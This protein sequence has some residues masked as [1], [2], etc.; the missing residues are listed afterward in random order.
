MWI[1]LEKKGLEDGGGRD[2]YAVGEFS[3]REQARRQEQPLLLE[4]QPAPQ[5]RPAA[6]IAADAGTALRPHPR[7]HRAKRF[8]PQKHHAQQVRG[9]GN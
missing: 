6:S 5:K 2:E 1:C 4:R 8:H 9:D 3:G 7:T